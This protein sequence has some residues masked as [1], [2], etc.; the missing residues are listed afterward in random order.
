MALTQEEIKTLTLT[1]DEFSALPEAARGLFKQGE[2]GAYVLDGVAPAKKLAEFRDENIRVRRELERF[3]DLDP[4][5]AKEA[6]TEVERL[7]A[8]IAA[9]GGDEKSAAE[10]EKLRIKLEAAEKREAARATEVEQL[11]GQVGKGEILRH[12]HQ[13]LPE[14]L[15]AS[16]RREVERDALDR[17]QYVAADNGTGGRIQYLED[18][19]PKF[20]D[21]GE[22]YNFDD[23]IRDDRKANPHRYRAAASGG[24]APGSTGG[25]P[26]AT[27]SREAL[28][29]PAKYRKLKEG[30][31]KRGGS[32]KDIAIA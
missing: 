20:N 2:G 14:D 8:E 25:A 27:F 17:W 28:Q 18:G 30:V 12:L 26:G 21:S 6:M 13:K 11:R 32:L 10:L 5:A 31:E 23:W 16:A 4:D 19:K 1:D 15:F 3:K 29:D 7:R 24:D 22:E 9:G